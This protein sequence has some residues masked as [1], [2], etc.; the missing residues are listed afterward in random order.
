VNVGLDGSFAIWAG[1]LAP[2]ERPVILVLPD[3]ERFGEALRELRRIGIDDVAGYLKGGI[4]AW[5]ASGRAVERL[6]QMPAGELAARIE[7]NGRAPLVLD[8]REPSEWRSGHIPGSRNVPAGDI[9]RGKQLDL[10]FDRPVAVICGSGYRS[11]VAA[12]LLQNAGQRNVVSVP[13][14]MDAWKRAR[15]P[16]E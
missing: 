14:G 11:S 15:Y 6:K 9:A 16:T 2:Y 8:V 4:A 1:W 7:A 13:E 12:S 5:E 10:P 3:D